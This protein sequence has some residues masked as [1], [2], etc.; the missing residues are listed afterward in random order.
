MTQS[1]YDPDLVEHLRRQL[2]FLRSSARAYDDGDAVEAVRIAIV[3]RVLCHDTGKSASLLGQ[4]G[5]KDQMQLVTTA[6]TLSSSE[7]Q[8]LDYAEL[9]GGMTFGA[10]P[11]YNPIPAGAP[12]IACP[13]WWEQP[14]FLRD[15]KLISRKLVVLSA[16]NKDGGAHVDAPN[17]NLMAMKDGFWIKTFTNADGV[18]ISEPSGNIHFR[19]LRRLADELLSSHEL[20]ALA[21]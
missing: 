1:A 17:A 19:M 9:L 11:T 7:Q 16:A 18:K 6:G 2:I 20:Q 3:I 8:Q 4:L 15:G 5:V 12:T 13:D 21:Q 14:V 10:N